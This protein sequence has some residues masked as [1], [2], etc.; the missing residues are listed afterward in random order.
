MGFLY[1]MFLFSSDDNY[2]ESE[3][4]TSFGRGILKTVCKNQIPRKRVSISLK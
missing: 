3:A 1:V 4:D 2:P